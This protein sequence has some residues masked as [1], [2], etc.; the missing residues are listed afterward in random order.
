LGER[1]GEKEWGERDRIVF[2]LFGDD[3]GERILIVEIDD[4]LWLLVQ[5]GEHSG[6]HRLSI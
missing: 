5:F 1:G 6:Q 4:V 2:F 3:V